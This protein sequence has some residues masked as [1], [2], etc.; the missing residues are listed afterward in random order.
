M[1]LAAIVSTSVLA[2][3]RAQLITFEMNDQII[4][5][6]QNAR[7][8]M[9]FVETVTR[10][11]CGGISSGNV[12]L[13]V[14]GATQQVQPCL[15]WYDGASVSATSFGVSS[16]TTL[17]DALEVVYGSGAMTGLAVAVPSLTGVTS[18]TVM[19]ASSFSINDYVLVEATDFSAANLY[20]ISSKVGNVLTFNASATT[21]SSAVSGALAIGSP[22]LKASTY[23]F[24]VAPAGTATYAGMLMVDSDGMVSTNHLNYNKVQPAVE[25]VVDFQVAIGIDGNSDGVLTDSSP[26]EFIGNVAGETLPATPWNSPTT[27]PQLRQVRLSL[28]LQTNQGYPGS[29]P[30][31]PAAS[32]QGFED[33]TT[34]TSVSPSPRYRSVRLVVA[35]RA[36]NLAE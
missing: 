8:A 25:G 13:N 33:R 30:M 20:K 36:W 28:L 34:Y 26:D 19:D 23:S 10:R 2:I 31:F 12:G 29:S 14:S 35:P 17:P 3:V 7:S 16:A 32:M 18:I 21:L 11:A 9:D 4:K 27:A 6:Q 5:T 15:R 22:V 24:F 1:A